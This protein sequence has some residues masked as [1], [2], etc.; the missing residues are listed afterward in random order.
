MAIG[1]V[2]SMLAIF[3][4]FW[5][6]ET[7]NPWLIMLG[8][9]IGFGGLFSVAYGGQ[10]A[11]FADAFTPEVRF[12]GMSLGYQAANVFGSGFAPI[13]AT[14]LLQYTGSPW[15]I[16]A[17]ISLTLVISMVCLMRLATLAARRRATAPTPQERNETDPVGTT[18]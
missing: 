3:G 8:Y 16:P 7:H 10:P 15:T 11:L 6:V 13:I 18:V 2:L 9:A 1:S 4:M 5:T 14:A 12:T 17:F